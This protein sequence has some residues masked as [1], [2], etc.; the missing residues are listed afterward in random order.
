MKKFYSYICNL[1]LIW[2]SILIY[3]LFP[4][5]SK[6][7]SSNTRIAL[8]VFAGGYTIFGFIFYLLS[9]K[10]Y[11]SSKGLLIIQYL[12]KFFYRIKNRE[13][14]K[15]ESDE[16][17]AVLFGLVKF[18]F[19]P[20]ML[21]FLFGNFSS[22][23]SSIP[24]LNIQSFTTVNGFNSSLFG[25]LL[26]L[27]FMLDTLIFTFG[28]MFESRLLKNKLRSVE[29][30]VFGWVIALACYPPFN[31][32]TGKVLNWYA[33]DH[34]A[35]PNEFYTFIFRI[36]I[37]LLL[38][39]YLSATFALGTKAS[40]LTNRGIVSNGPYSI[41]RHPAYISKNLA[42]FITIIPL[43]SFVGIL[44]GIG[45]AFIYHLRA[46]TEERHLRKDPDYV[47]YCKKVKYRYI[48]GIY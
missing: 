12:K 2:I 25:V 38:S 17:N 15:A 40:N 1:I 47:E 32:M 8:L 48:P 4:F 34:Y 33:N 31:G 3:F 22:L 14:A 11:P 35:F 27:I 23:I 9:S 44:S 29:P 20:I 5:Y 39:I 36:F 45:W 37:V 43:G 6:F 7:L 41:V 24:R 13:F 26:N 21:N 19:L 30:T 42:W 28:Y 16:K 18:F 10:E 46:I